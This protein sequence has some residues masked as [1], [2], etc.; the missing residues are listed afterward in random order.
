MNES[1]ERNSRIKELKR[2]RREARKRLHQIEADIETTLTLAEDLENQINAD[3][4]KLKRTDPKS[5][6]EALKSPREALISPREALK[7][8]RELKLAEL[9]HSKSRS[10]RKLKILELKKNKSKNSKDLPRARPEQRNVKSPRAIEPKNKASKQQKSWPSSNN[11]SSNNGSDLYGKLPTNSC[12]NGNYSPDDS[13][14]YN[15]F[16][17]PESEVVEVRKPTFG[18]GLTMS[19]SGDLCSDTTRVAVILENARR[20]EKKKQNHNTPDKKEK[21]STENKTQ[22]ME[23][24]EEKIEQ[25]ENEPQQTEETENTSKN[26]LLDSVVNTKTE[27]VEIVNNHQPEPFLTEMGK[28]EIVSV[29]GEQD[30]EKELKEKEKQLNDA[31]EQNQVANTV[32]TINDKTKHK[33]EIKTHKD[34]TLEIEKNK[35]H[36][37]KKQTPTQNTSTLENERD[38]KEPEIVEKKEKAKKE[39]RKNGEGNTK[40]KRRNI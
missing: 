29:K 8:P 12:E 25:K 4:E 31:K 35:T 7:S 23:T 34:Q 20:K 10:P 9:Q 19:S 16:S 24:N 15:P 11:N 3:E 14:T 13:Y 40:R 38:V 6:Q 5:P 32:E 26:M 1:S 39:K 30:L 33:E 37:T 27:T 36:K 2:R 17:L 21:E 22:L 28:D 18:F